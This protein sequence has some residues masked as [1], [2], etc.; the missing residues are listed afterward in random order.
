[1]QVFYLCFLHLWQVEY[2]VI[3]KMETINEDIDF[4]TEQSGL[5]KYNITLPWA[6][7]KSSSGEN[8]SL[9]YFQQLSAEQ[10]KQLH[11]IFLPDF[12]MFGYDVAKYL[13]I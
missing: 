13:E 9:K 5:A 7:K 6:N 8:P 12:E 1:M 4:I 11:Q 3:G 10:V 2:D